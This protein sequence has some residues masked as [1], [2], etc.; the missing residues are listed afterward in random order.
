M[1]DTS[2]LN[3][4]VAGSI[5]AIGPA[6][7]AQFWLE[8]EHRKVYFTCCLL[9]FFLKKLKYLGAVNMRY[10][11]SPVRLRSSLQTDVAQAVEQ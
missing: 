3:D 9:P 6:S 8:Q 7:V 2:T 1:S 11:V 10:F 4:Q 5:P